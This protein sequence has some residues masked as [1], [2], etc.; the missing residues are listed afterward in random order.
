MPHIARL[1]RGLSK[2]ELKNNVEKSSISEKIF[3]DLLTPTS[4]LP[5]FISECMLT[6]NILCKTKKKQFWYV[7]LNFFNINFTQKVTH[8]IKM[9]AS[10]IE[11]PENR[12]NYNSVILVIEMKYVIK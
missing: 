12:N 7:Q 3:K 2:T 1:R 9:F 5:F 11:L 6:F 10:Y 4:I 8:Y